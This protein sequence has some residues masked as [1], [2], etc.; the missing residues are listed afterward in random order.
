MII[1]VLIFIDVVVFIMIIV[2]A[3]VSHFNDELLSYLFFKKS[4]VQSLF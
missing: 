2:I 3:V 1:V 4:N